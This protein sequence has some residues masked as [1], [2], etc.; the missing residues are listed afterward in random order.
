MVE[1]TYQRFL[2]LTREPAAAAMLTL[3]EAI[4]AMQIVRPQ[5]NGLP[6]LLTEKEAI[7]YLRLNVD[8]RDPAERLRNLVRRQRLPVVRRGR[9]LLFRR[10]SVDE[11][12]AKRK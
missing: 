7:V 9:L 8:A 2:E 3:T 1:A 12:L 6:A 11:W 5:S 10:A 4:Q